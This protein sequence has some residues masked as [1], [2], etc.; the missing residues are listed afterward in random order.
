[1]KNKDRPLSLVEQY[2]LPAGQIE[3]RSMAII[4]G[5]LPPSDDS[6]QALAVVHRIVHTTGDLSLADQIKFHQA[7]LPAGIQAL[8]TGCAII[9]DVHMVEAGISRP[10]M[11][12]LGCSLHCVI[13]HPEVYA[14]AD[15]AGVT[16]SIAAMRWLA[17]PT[18]SGGPVLDGAIVAIGNAPTA[19]LALLD[20]VDAGVVR[21]ALI[22]GVPVGFVAAAES[23]K[24][25]MDR[26]TPYITL[27][28][29]RGGSTIA[30]ATVNALLRLA[31]GQ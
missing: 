2:A 6:Q 12:K 28:G 24:E 31:A 7:A 9:T 10:L 3:P 19:L 13:D 18:S 11:E 14:M 26:D 22:V 23:K 20:L 4:Q 1:M 21:P 30:V 8:K 15:S 5:L 29:T 27:P 25:L 16:R 17:Q